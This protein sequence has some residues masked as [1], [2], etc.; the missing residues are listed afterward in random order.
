MSSST[1]CRITTNSLDQEK[2]VK[3]RKTPQVDQTQSSVDDSMFTVNVEAD[4]LARVDAAIETI[5]W[6]EYQWQLALTCSF[7][8]LVDQVRLDPSIFTLNVSH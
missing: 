8:F 6:G 3:D 5:G 4:N 1:P 7:G 2:G